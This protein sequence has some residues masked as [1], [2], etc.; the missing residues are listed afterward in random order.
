[1]VLWPSAPDAADRQTVSSQAL[2]TAG[3]RTLPLPLMGYAFFAAS[4]PCCS[5]YAWRHE[6][7]LR[8]FGEG[9]SA[10]CHLGMNPGPSA[11]VQVGVPF[12]EVGAVRNWTDADRHA[13]RNNQDAQSVTPG[14]RFCLSAL[15][16]VGPAFVGPCLLNYPRADDF[17]R[18]LRAE[19]LPAGVLRQGAQRHRTNCRRRKRRRSTLPVTRTCVP[20]SM[21]W[22][23][24]G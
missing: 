4:Y 17:C 14:G 24:S 5:D 22:R 13:G 6:E 20:V 11:W 12:G 8:R 23:R 18:S 15:G 2:I 10:R 21:R 19:L 1:M 16:G 7:Y 9:R 3:R